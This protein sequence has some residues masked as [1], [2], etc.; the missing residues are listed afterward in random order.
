MIMKGSLP[1]IL[2]KG[3]PLS[4]EEPTSDASLEAWISWLEENEIEEPEFIEKCKEQFKKEGDSS[5]SVL[6]FF[7]VM[8]AY[9]HGLIPVIDALTLYKFVDE[10]MLAGLLL[11]AKLVGLKKAFAYLLTRGLMKTVCSEIG[12]TGKQATRVMV[13]WA[14]TVLLS[15]FALRQSP[16]LHKITRNYWLHRKKF[17]KMMQ[18]KLPEETLRDDLLWEKNFNR[19]TF[20]KEI[21]S[22][23]GIGSSPYSFE[24]I[25][26]EQL[27]EIKSD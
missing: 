2:S 18:E 3:T 25:P 11:S 8:S 15:Q 23:Q 19:A 17:R 7:S 1:E 4:V 20:L 13:P 21:L 9:D 27:C 14:G 24:P 5:S 22:A 12:V 10:G 6:K 16:E 26:E